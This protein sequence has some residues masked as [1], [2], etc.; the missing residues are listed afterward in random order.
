MDL[1]IETSGLRKEYRSRRRH[2]VAVDGL[3]LRVAAGGGVHGLI[4]PNGSGKT[5]TIRLL[6]GLSRP[7]GGTMRLFGRPVPDELPA[8]I[9]RVGAVVESPRFT[10]GFSGRLNLRLLGD[11]LGVPRSEVDAALETVQI[12]SRADDRYGTYSL[13]MRQRLAIAATLLKRPDL[14]I[15]DEPTN[16]LDP[17]GIREVRDTIRGL[18]ANGVTVL[19]SSHLLA[20][21]EQV[22]TAATIVGR[23]RVLAS[24]TVADL[25]GDSDAHLVEVAPEDADHALAALSAAG[26]GVVHE[27]GGVLRVSAADP[28]RITRTLG[29]D[30]VWLRRLDPLARDLESVFLEL[31]RGAELGAAK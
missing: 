27:G 31:T 8:V 3:D 15:L 25:L 29:K 16:G 12:D 5:T 18:G 19:L 4:G 30:G 23:G 13:G 7:T 17:L 10:P 26:L 11:V 14:L 20:E 9:G 28:A 6:L 1:A 22:C 21:I 2:H 24:G